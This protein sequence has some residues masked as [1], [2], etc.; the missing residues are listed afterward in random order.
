MT[1]I[2]S[3][4]PTVD[5]GDDSP[6]LL[7]QR[8]IRYMKT[9]DDRKKETWLRLQKHYLIE[10]YR[11]LVECERDPITRELAR[12]LVFSKG[13]FWFFSRTFGVVYEPRKQLETGSGLLPFIPFPHQEWVAQFFFAVYEDGETGLVLK[14]RD[15]AVSWMTYHQIAWMW[16]TNEDFSCLF[17]SRTEDQVDG[18]AGKLDH[19]TM[20]GRIEIIISNLPSWLRQGI[21]WT[22]KDQR[23]KLWWLNPNNGNV[24]GGEPS[25]G[26]FGRQGRFTLGMLDE[27]EHWEDPL[28]AITAVRDA[29][30]AVWLVTTPSLK[31]GGVAQRLMDETDIRVMELSWEYHPYKTS[32]WYA[33]QR[34]GRLAESVA[35]EL[36]MSLDGN[37]SLLIYPE[38]SRVPKGSFPFRP[39]WHTYGGIDFGRS[40][41]CGLVWVQRSPISLR[42]RILASY[43]RSGEEIDHFFPFMGGPLLSGHSDYNT[44]DLEL[45]DL[46]RSWHNSQYGVEWFGDPAGRQRTI[47]TNKSVLERLAQARIHVITNSRA[48]SHEDRQSSVRTL[49]RHCD[50][51]IEWCGMLDWSMKRYKRANPTANSVMERRNK[52]VHNRATHVPAGLEYAAVNMPSEFSNTTQEE[53]KRRKPIWER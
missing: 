40:D 33:R 26:N 51:N 10:R 32:D 47:T 46:T 15:M 43:Y 44:R 50:V 31:G 11:F 25:T 16:L 2:S 24:L 21:D 13:G 8:L 49:L 45:I 28:G 3:P 48:V 39:D 29:C 36:D 35:T 1:S 38:W 14:T 5:L 17:G 6:T 52:P 53:P 30:G 9:N 22:D 12:R 27:F 41:G 37:Q 20:F 4:I 42:S 7:R 19:R 34:S 23:Q 18:S